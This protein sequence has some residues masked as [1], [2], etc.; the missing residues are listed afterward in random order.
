MNQLDFSQDSSNPYHMRQRLSKKE[1]QFSLYRDLRLAHKNRL[2][3]GHVGMLIGSIDSINDSGC[4]KA[5]R[6]RVMFSAGKLVPFSYVCIRST[7][8][9]RLHTSP[10]HSWCALNMSF[11]PLPV[12][13]V[14][15][16]I[17]VSTWWH[18]FAI[19]QTMYI[20]IDQCSFRCQDDDHSTWVISLLD[21]LESRNWNRVRGDEECARWMY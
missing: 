8:F 4:C 3:C 9:G 5:R 18:I 17:R 10:Q 19:G 20:S 7:T 15:L 14:L 21:W 12:K 16:S 13:T 11:L 2:W 6:C 1:K